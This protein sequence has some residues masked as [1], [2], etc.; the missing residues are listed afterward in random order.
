M[1]S[2]CFALQVNGSADK[3]SISHNF[4]HL[5]TSLSDTVKKPVLKESQ[6]MSLRVD[7]FKT[8]RNTSRRML[9]AFVDSVFQFI[10]QQLFPSQKN[11]APVDEIGE[12]VQ[13]VCSEGRFPVGIYIR[14]GPNPLFGGLKSTFSIFGRSRDIWVEGEG[15]LHALY[16]MKDDHGDWTISYKN[17]YVDPETF[18]LK[19]QRNRPSF[20]PTAQGD[21]LAILA[22]PFSFVLHFLAWLV[23]NSATQAFLSI[24]GG[25]TL[26]QRTTSLKRLTYS[27]W[28]PW[29]SGISTEIGTGLSLAIQRKLQELGTMDGNKLSHKVDLKFN[30]G[31][32]LHEIA[33]ILSLLMAIWYNVIMDYP[34][35]IDISRLLRG[36]RLIKYDKG[37]SARIGVMARYGDADS[38]RWF[39]VESHCTFH[40]VN[41]FEDEQVVI[42]GCRALDSIIPG[43]NQG[44]NKPNENSI[45]LA[46][47]EDLFTRVYEWRLN[48][49]TGEV[50]EKNLTGMDFCMDFPLINGEI[51]LALS[52]SLPKCGGI[53]KIFF[54]EQDSMLPKNGQRMKVKC[55]SFGENSFCT[56]S[57]FASKVGSCVE[58]DGWIVSFVHIENTDVSQVHIIDASKFNCEPIAKITLPQRVPY[59][60]H[61][62]FIPITNQT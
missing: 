18:K 20:L 12:A 34:L 21:S 48:M 26:S 16:F 17:R 43:P 11:F 22:A 15:M 45:S 37:D 4:G 61:G 41:S 6:K 38:V 31:T 50:K 24:R 39:S 60:F 19:K 54:E 9:D 47:D 7:I 5:K 28:R 56:G 53:A 59:G 23:R 36:D 49:E 29:R 2:T 51:I 32:F 25:T 40:I 35:T 27:L 55:H 30:R 8:I 3:L 58:D 57:A 44:L 1:A 42:R 33:L 46:K 13:V 14:N 10:D 62:T 52:T